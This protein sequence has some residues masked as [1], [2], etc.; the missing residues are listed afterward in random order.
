MITFE[1]YLNE[2]SE[3]ITQTL[4][5][6]SILIGSSKSCHIRVA[7]E[8]LPNVALRLTNTEHGLLAEGNEGLAYKVNFKKV[9]GSKVLKTNDRINIGNS[10]IILKAIDYSL[11]NAP[12]NLEALYE[13]FHNE[14]EEYEAV[15]SAIEKELI[16]SDDGVA[17]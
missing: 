2:K 12:L 10:T 3:T 15:L 5:F 16:L 1:I 9:I 6:R 17:R 11:S 14:S 8:D 13:K 7:G 4:Y